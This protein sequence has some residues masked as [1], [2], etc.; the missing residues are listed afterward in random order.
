MRVL[1]AAVLLAVCMSATPQKKESRKK[2]PDV[3]MMETT[4]RRNGETFTLDG[5]VHITSEKVVRGLVMVF[6]F[7]GPE[8][9]VIA[10]QKA[11]VSEDD[12][13]PGKDASYQAVT[14]A[15]PRAVHYK[16]RAFDIN[17][18]ELRIANAG[19]FAIE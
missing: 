18:K 9:S 19:P 8:G 5:R 17:E 7:F 4:V 3:Q 6:D 16:L 13:E 1:A 10:T 15:P 11:Q 2:P 12:L 14:P